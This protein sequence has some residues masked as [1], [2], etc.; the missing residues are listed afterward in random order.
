ML[1]VLI[2]FWTFPERDIITAVRC[3]IHLLWLM[4]IVEVK[5][6][7][8]KKQ[9]MWKSIIFLKYA[10]PRLLFASVYDEPHITQF[11]V[12]KL[13]II[14]VSIAVFPKH[15]HKASSN[16]S[17]CALCVARRSFLFILWCCLN[18]ITGTSALHFICWCRCSR[19]KF[20]FIIRG[21]NLTLEDTRCPG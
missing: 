17:R 7:E 6:N 14:I 15:H 10:T 4:W 9:A 12:A 21:V 3:K 18:A 11:I 13:L 19:F 5:T 16:L 8:G 2:H 1:I 20:F